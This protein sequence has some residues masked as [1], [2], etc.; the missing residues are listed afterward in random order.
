ME[1]HDVW[2][3]NAPTHAVENHDQINQLQSNLY[4]GFQ[5]QYELEMESWKNSIS[6]R[7]ENILQ[8]HTRNLEEQVIM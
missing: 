7:H 2:G 6:S 3:G 5:Q 4:Q 8:E 1:G